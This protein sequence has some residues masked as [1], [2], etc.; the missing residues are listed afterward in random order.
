MGLL[1]PHKSTVT[2]YPDMV[3]VSI[4]RDTEH[5]GGGKRDAIH[6]F[7]RESRYRLFRLLHTLRFET[8]SFVTL[9]YGNSFPGSANIA[10]T[11]LKAFRRATERRYGRISGIWRM[12][13]QQRGAIHFHIL[14]LDP[15]FIPVQDWCRVWDD[16]RHAPMEERYGNSLDLKANAIPEM[17]GIVGK[18]LGKYIAKEDARSLESF[19]DNPGRIWGRWNIPETPPVVLEI[20]PLEKTRLDK[21]LLPADDAPC[22]HPSNKDA[23]TIFGGTMGKEDLKDK[24][25]WELGLLLGY[26]R[27]VER[28][29]M[30]FVTWKPVENELQ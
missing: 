20:S 10:K 9:T 1:L 21:L 7:S 30:P 11:H 2:I 5:K 17:G 25:L 24:V 26:T 4:N 19:S 13:L 15:P 14:Y 3:T 23:Y 6:C 22:W 8:F 29:K 18:Y 12:E 28:P 16:A 27:K